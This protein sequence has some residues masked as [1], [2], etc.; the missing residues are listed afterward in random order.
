MQV[1]AAA[2]QRVPA[3]GQGGPHRVLP[4]AKVFEALVHKVLQRHQGV[5]VGDGPGK[6]VQRARV[7]GKSCVDQVDHVLRH[8]V[9]RK[10]GGWRHGAGAFGTKAFAV[11]GVKSPLAADGLFAFHQDAVALAHFAVKELHAQLF[12]VACPL[13]KFGTAAQKVRVGHPAQQHLGLLGRLL[14]QPFHAPSSSLQH[15]Q[16]L[17][18]KAFQGEHE[19]PIKVIGQLGVVHL[20]VSTWPAATVRF[21]GKVPHARQETRDPGFMVPDFARF[22]VGFDHQ[23]LVLRRV[24]VHQ[25]RAVPTKLVAQHQD[26]VAGHAE[27]LCESPE[28]EGPRDLSARQRSLQYRTL[29]QFL[30]QLLRHTMARP[31]TAHG[32]CGKLCL[33][34]LNPGV[35]GML[36]S[37]G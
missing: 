15:Q 27:A 17:G 33:F 35:L 16:G 4:S 2:H 14:D 19:P 10:A 6:V 3:K 32:F 8:A 21:V 13:G 12:F 34:P 37:A 28:L 24:K 5:F 36:F 26:R 9:G 11:L 30:A 31:Q 7:S 29:S 23:Q 25:S 22:A 1:Q 18:L 20:H